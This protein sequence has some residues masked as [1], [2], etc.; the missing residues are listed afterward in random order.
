VTLKGEIRSIRVDHRPGPAAD[1]G[2]SGLLVHGRRPDNRTS[3]CQV[4]TLPDGT[5][6]VSSTWR[7][8]GARPGEVTACRSEFTAAEWAELCRAPEN[9]VPHV[10]NRILDKRQRGSR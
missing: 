6:V 3:A 4:A 7:A 2:K 1:P 10:C 8:P 5:V 9:L